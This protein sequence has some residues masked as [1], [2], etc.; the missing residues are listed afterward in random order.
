MNFEE[1]TIQNNKIPILANLAH[2]IWNEYWTIILTQGQIDYMVEKFQSEN[3]IKKQLK[4]D[5]YR[6]FFIKDKMEN[7]GYIGLQDKTEYL[8][9][10]KLYLKKNF[11]HKGFGTKA[12]NFITQFAKENNFEKIILTVNKNNKNTIEAYKKWGFDII[13]SVVT[14]IGNNYVMDDY[15]MEYKIKSG[16]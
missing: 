14:D 16:C 5:N 1:I 2:E 15:I 6:Y 13:N 4:N 8:F 9:L 7:I 10:S 11:R 3:A 12:F